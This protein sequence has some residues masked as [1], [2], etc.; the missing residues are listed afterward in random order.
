M[1]D[2][3]LNPLLWRYTEEQNV[4]EDKHVMLQCSHHYMRHQ[5]YNSFVKTA[6]YFHTPTI[7]FQ[8]M[9]RNIQD[10]NEEHRRDTAEM[11]LQDM[12]AIA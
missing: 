2:K 3:Y 9:C 8:V 4:N 5:I 7:K 10:L 12:Q 6:V 11:V 1:Q